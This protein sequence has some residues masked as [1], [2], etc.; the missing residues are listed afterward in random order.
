MVKIESKKHQSKAGN[1][2]DT[3]GIGALLRQAREAKGLSLEEVFEKTKL[4]SSIISAIENEQWDRLPSPVFVKGFIRTY[5]GLLEMDQKEVIGLYEAQVPE[6]N[7]PFEAIL[8]KKQARKPGLLILAVVV[9]AIIGLTYW[10]V[11]QPPSKMPTSQQPTKELEPAQEKSKNVSEGI[12]AELNR[13]KGSEEPIELTKKNNA[14]E[15][16]IRQ[17]EA[18]LPPPDKDTSYDTATAIQPREDKP[19]AEPETKFTLKG[20]VIERTWMRVI[21]DDGPAKE[22]IFEPGS[23]PVWKAER[24][25]DIMIGNAAGIT[26]QLNGKPLGPFGRRGKVVHIVLP[27]ADG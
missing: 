23:H 4:R 20:D 21:T 17:P 18:A 10:W 8:T 5:A 24:G 14:P 19:A 2:P 13:A 25:F 7:R 3:P 12:A 15:H 27:G 9:M 6:E 11:E 1:G 16:T 22:Y 26:L